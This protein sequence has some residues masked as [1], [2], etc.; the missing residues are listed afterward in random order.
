MQRDH[1]SPESDPHEPQHS[2]AESA[3]R[4]AESAGFADGAPPPEGD[5]PEEA[6]WT[7]PKTLV[8]AAAEWRR[9]GASRR[10]LDR[11]IMAVIEGMSE[12]FLALDSGWRVTFA[13]EA[14]ANLSDTTPESL[15][16]CDFWEQWPEAVGTE[17]ERRYRRAVAQRRP[18]HFVH[19]FESGAWHDIR[20]YPDEDGG[21]VVLFRDATRE[22]ELEAERARQARALRAAHEKAKAAEEQF[23]LLVDRVRDYAIF[24]LDPEGRITHWG[25]GARRMKGYTADEVKGRHLGVLYPPDDDAAAGA[26]DEHLRI[27]ARQ[28]E[29]TGEGTRVRKDGTRFPAR[30]VLT[31]LRRGGALVGFSNITQD[32][33]PERERE[34]VLARA[35]AAAEAA[36]IAKS[37]FL[38]T[39]SHEIR[40]PLN[41]VTGYAELLE[42]EI[43]GPLT[44]QQRQYVTRIQ[45][46]SRHLL[47]LVN[48]VIDLSKIEAGALRPAREAGRV[49]DATAAALAL[50]EP[51]ARARRIALVNGCASLTD[52]AYRGDTARVRQILVNLLSNAVRFTEPGGRVTVS[53]GV[54]SEAPPEAEGMT[55]GPWTVIRVEDTGGG[56][57]PEQIERIWEA[58]VQVDQSRTRRFGGSGLGLTISRHLARLMGGEITVHSTPELGSS[59]V[60]W[61]PNAPGE[62]VATD[63]PAVAASAGTEDPEAALAEIASAE[64]TTLRE[65]AETMLADVERIVAT[66]GAR[67]RTDPATPSAHAL[68]EAESVDHAVTFVADVLLCLLGIAD[69]GE[70]AHALLEDGSE[71]QRLIAARHGEQRARLDWSAEEIRRDYVI[72]REELASAARRRAARRP[73]ALA[74]AL[75]LIEHYVSRAEE[76]SLTAFAATA[77]R[78]KPGGEEDAQRA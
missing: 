19:R 75:G 71:I 51:Q 36:S 16:G 29:Y 77:P 62:S 38:A 45:T 46:T 33:T 44:A 55:M 52:T 5:Q 42:M 69:D 59:F 10:S 76:V 14:A 13:N 1:A 4:A 15:L 40:T 18:E 67:L 31:A 65:I 6:P 22:K 39:T 56:I 23:R 78:P 66:Y 32:L 24:L 9:R 70:E 63:A 20:A 64:A 37:Q 49:S 53:C 30:I 8:E 35:T 17:V 47:S 2:S 74:R 41:A 48:D 7:R 34:R 28:G 57:A 68:G 60:L 12:A 43:G 3:D 61:L 73:G 50:V 27:A 11:R 72:L 25:E 54:V 21:L 58:F 26:A